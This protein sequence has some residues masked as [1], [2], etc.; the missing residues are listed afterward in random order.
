MVT[1]G[2]SNDAAAAPPSTAYKH[3]W[4]ITGPAGCGKTSVAEYLHQ[5]FSLPY[6]EGDTF[7]TAANVQ[8]MAAGQPLTDADRWDWLILL[9]EQS[10]ATLAP[11]GAS[12]P[13]G[14]SGVIVTCSALKRKYR[15]V[16]R[17]AAYHDPSIRVHFVFL[18]ASET[19]LMDR[20]RARKNHYMKDYMVHSQFE[21]LETP[22]AD[23]GDVLS[24]DASGTSGEVQRLAL[25]VV[26]GEMRGGDRL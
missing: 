21:S 22:M 5:T 20:V 16:I 12:S 18:S 6:L 19:L 1:N 3:I 7:H 15:D 9:R 17:I 24:V 10:L 23:E 4:V 8:K 2:V 11:P 26:E 13:G 14:P 25:K